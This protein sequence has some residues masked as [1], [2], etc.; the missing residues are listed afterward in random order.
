MASQ[1]VIAGRISCRHAEASAERIGCNLPAAI[2]HGGCAVRSKRC[3]G[4]QDKPA[5]VSR[6][7]IR[8][9]YHGDWGAARAGMAAQVSVTFEAGFPDN[10]GLVPRGGCLQALQ[11]G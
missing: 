11:K 2:V 10:R 8:E 7:K 9:L 5:M 6:D 1:V 3:R 4:C